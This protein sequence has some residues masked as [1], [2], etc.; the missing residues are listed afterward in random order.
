MR[1][2]PT[3]QPDV[4]VANAGD[5]IE[6]PDA[7][8]ART[9]SNRHLAVSVASVFL[10]PWLVWGSAVAQAHGLITWRLPQ[11][12][13]LWVLT[14]SV[15]VGALVVG[16]R[17]ALKDLVRRVL[18]WRAPVWVYLAAVAL[19]LAIGAGTVAVSAVTGRPVH[20][21]ETEGLAGCL[22]YFTYAVGLFLLTEEAGWTGLLLP[23]LMVRMPWLP[24]SLVLGVVWGLW[25]LPL[26]NVPGQRDHGLPFAAFL[27]F[28]VATRVLMT[29]LA[30]VSRMAVPVAAVFHAAIDATS[31]YVGVVGGDHSVIWSAGVVTAS[32][33]VVTTVVTRGRVL[34]RAAA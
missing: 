24:A 21:G 15:V 14:P 19:P 2:D 30:T 5:P 26:L 18:R 22:V 7:V 31:V 12:T 11:G 6:T 33:A 8:V 29:A 9:A 25:H 3:A 13:A 32:L 4:T 27:L 10:L 34:Q 28:I 16:G 20:L 1:T 23:R 17:P